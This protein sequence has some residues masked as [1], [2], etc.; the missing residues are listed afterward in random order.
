MEKSTQIFP[1]IKNQK[2]AFNSKKDK[3]YYPLEFSEEYKYV[4]KKKEAYV[5]Y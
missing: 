5:Y 2:K 4:V 1:I 3:N